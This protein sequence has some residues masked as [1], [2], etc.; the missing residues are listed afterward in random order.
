MYNPSI[1]NTNSRRKTM[2]KFNIHAHAVLFN[3][4]SI[5]ICKSDEDARA[6]A[7]NAHSKSLHAE[8]IIHVSCLTPS[9]LKKA[10]VLNGAKL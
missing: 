7:Y 5:V 9:E 8:H 1:V 4:G 2:S 3:D 6:L 10:I